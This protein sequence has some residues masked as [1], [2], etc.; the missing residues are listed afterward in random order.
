[1]MPVEISNEKLFETLTIIILDVN[2][3]CNV[4]SNEN[5]TV[6][7]STVDDSLKYDYRM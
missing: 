5:I 3:K 4:I 6:N 2:S 7:R 1:M